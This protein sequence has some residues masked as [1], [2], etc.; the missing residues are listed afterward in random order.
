[1]TELNTS[2]MI[3]ERWRASLRDRNKSKDYIYSNFYDLFADLK[4][5]DIS[6]DSAYLYLESAIKEHLPAAVLIKTLYKNRPAMAKRISETEFAQSWKDLIRDAAI[7]AFYD[8]YPLKSAQ[9]DINYNAVKTEEVDALP[10]GWSREE[11]RLQRAHADSFPQVD[12]SKVKK[13]SEEDFMSEDF[14]V[15]NNG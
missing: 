11:Y 9:D 14:G 12:F 3:Y 2:K 13:M 7:K 1:M 4:Y 6:L 15:T 10:G 5:T 8:V